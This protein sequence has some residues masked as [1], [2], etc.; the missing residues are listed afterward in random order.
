MTKSKE[1]NVELISVGQIVE[2]LHFGPF[3]HNW[4]LA[5][6]SNKTTHTFLFPVRLGMKTL[7]VLNNCN[8]IITVV[9]GYTEHP[10][11]PG[12]F[13]YAEDK[14]SGVYGSSTE[15]INACYKEVF[16]SSNAKFPGLPVMGFDN[17]NI[18]EQLFSDVI[19]RPYTFKLGKLNI[20]VL[21][22][23]KSKKSEWN[24]AGDGYKSVFQ[25]N[26]N[27]IRQ[28]FVQE[29]GYKKCTV[30]IF[31]D[32][33]L[34][35]QYSASDPNKVWLDIGKFSN[36]T[37]KDLFGLEYLYTQDCIEQVQ[38]PSCTVVHWTSEG[39]LEE[40][41]IYHLKRRTTHGIKWRDFF[42]KW[43]N[44]KSSI[45]E[46]RGAILDLY[47]QNYEISDREWRAWK[48]F[49]RNAGCTNITPFKKEE[50]KV[51]KI[52]LYYLFEIYFY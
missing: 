31:I 16:R 1:Y 18:V 21:G 19:F 43:L 25:T 11:S 30:Q 39:V 44:Q 48:A 41:Y 22:M 50:S 2:N 36:Y 49:I 42:D 26:S 15:A 40:L 17:S 7:T 12:F 51:S 34:V 10:N 13:C 37:G 46:L 9:K 6:S 28:I 35:K 3:C 38:I 20:F 47:P 27:N 8:F 32:N 23:G 52:K 4:W 5:R 45:I 24:Y 14:Q 29:M 33:N